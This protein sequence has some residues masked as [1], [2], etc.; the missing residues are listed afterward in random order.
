MKALNKKAKILG[1]SM[2]VAGMFAMSP[3]AQAA[4]IGIYGSI[5]FLGN[6]TVKDSAGKVLTSNFNAVTT[7][8]TAQKHGEAAQLVFP[9]GQQFTGTG[10][11]TGA[12]VGVGDH[13][14]ASFSSFVFNPFPSGG[15]SPL[16]SVAFDGFT[17]S[18]A[19]PIDWAITQAWVKP[20][21]HSKGTYGSGLTI[22]GTGT[23]TSTNLAYHATPDAVFHFSTQA[24]GTTLLTI[25]A[26]TLST[27]LPAALFFVAPA[28]LG[29]FGVSRRKDAAG[30][31]A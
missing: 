9:A 15:V 5:S 13:A 7:G 10:T 18:M 28:L 27:P 26:S 8:T 4:G 31:A 19:S 3:A 25:S 29:L 11:Q 21:D 1:I 14:Q 17:F 24:G 12:F 20:S 16:W 22:D 6:N 23:L 30:S 2:A